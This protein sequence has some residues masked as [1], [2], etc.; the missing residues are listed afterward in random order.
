[1][2]YTQSR[3]QGA[4]IMVEAITQ[5]STLITQA[6]KGVFVDDE[7]GAFWLTLVVVLIIIVFI[8][9]KLLNRNQG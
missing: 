1:M 4:I 9:N 2:D 5:V 8:V 6:I 3:K 7:I